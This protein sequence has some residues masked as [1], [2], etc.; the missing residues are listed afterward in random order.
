MDCPVIFSKLNMGESCRGWTLYK[1]RETQNW[2]SN[3]RI[4]G[5]A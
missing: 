2:I 3:F 5:C 1:L 4:Y